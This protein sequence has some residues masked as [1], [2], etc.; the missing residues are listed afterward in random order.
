MRELNDAVIASLAAALKAAVQS[1][2]DLLW[3][4]GRWYQIGNR[5]EVKKRSKRIS[6]AARLLHEELNTADVDTVSFIRVSMG[7]GCPR[8][9]GPYVAL[10]KRLADAARIAGNKKP[11]NPW[12]DFR[13]LFVSWL[14]EDVKEL[15][16]HLGVKVQERIYEL[17]A[18]YLPGELTAARSATTLRRI[19]RGAKKAKKKQKR[20]DF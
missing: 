9:L 8:S 12:R 18:P 4:I 2:I 14:A 11:V 3:P 13:E 10:T 20:S 15:G 7:A 6:R 16:G 17:L 19:S 1:T 5:P